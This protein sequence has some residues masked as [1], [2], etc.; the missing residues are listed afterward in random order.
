MPGGVI[1]ALG[2]VNE[3]GL[4]L[5]GPVGTVGV[6]Q[7]KDKSNLPLTCIGSI[8]YEPHKRGSDSMA[9]F[10]NIFLIVSRPFITS[11]AS[12]LQICSLFSYF[13]L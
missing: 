9:I 13:I 6:F 5:S 11:L 12:S 2:F 10:I 7:P 1:G 4:I 8:L 3:T